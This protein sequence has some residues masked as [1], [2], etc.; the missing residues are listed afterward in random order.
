[1][2]EPTRFRFEIEMPELCPRSIA[3]VEP[4]RMV[5]RPEP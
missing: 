1:M 2:P 4:L 5:A 3:G